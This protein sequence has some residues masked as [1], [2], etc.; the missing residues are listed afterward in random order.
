MPPLKI[1]ASSEK[2]ILQTDASDE[3]WAAVLLVQSNSGKREICGYKSGTFRAS[4][5]HYHSTFK[6]ILAVKRGIERFQFHLIGHDFLVEMDMS[7]FP[8]MLEFKRKMLPQPQLL[9]WE[10]WFSQWKFTVKHIKGTSNVLADFLSRPS[11]YKRKCLDLQEAKLIFHHS[12][13]F[14]PMVIPIDKASSSSSSKPEPPPESFPVLS[15]PEEVSE[16]IADIT[17]KQRPIPNYQN[18]LSILIHHHGLFMKQDYP[19][20]GVY[21]IHDLFRLPKEALCFFWYMFESFTI[22]ISFNSVKLL[23]YILQCQLDNVPSRSLNLF[24]LLQWFLP[25]HQWIQKLSPCQRPYVVIMFRRPC[26]YLPPTAIRNRGKAFIYHSPMAFNYDWFLI[27]PAGATCMARNFD[28][29]T[30]IRSALARAKMV[31]PHSIPTQIMLQMQDWTED[32][33]VS[34]KWIEAHN[35]WQMSHLTPAVVT[36][37]SFN[38][39]ELAPS[40]DSNGSYPDPDPYEPYEDDP[41]HPYDPYQLALTECTQLVEQ[42]IIEPTSSPW[43]CEAF[44]VNKRSERVR[45]KLRLVI[46]YQPLNHFLAD[47]K[48]PLPQKK[49]LF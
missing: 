27:N 26:S 41:S 6:E 39:E 37:D 38:D 28:L 16:A 23:S 8:R 32:H 19:F 35:K 47:D 4:K 24:K 36:S 2:R 15:L 49:S 44:Y 7:S 18:F 29:Y 12:P 14:L 22:G 48:F 45:G 34:S 20:L 5:H 3:C 10:N 1:P 33:P 13:K 31:N 40:D 42:M 17:F 30:N 25:A 9:R 46:N 11:D 21:H 43:A